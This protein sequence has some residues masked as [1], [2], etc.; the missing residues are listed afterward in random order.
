MNAMGL[1]WLIA[2]NP[3]IGTTCL[4]TA[5]ILFLIKSKEL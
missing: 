4:C 2:G 1:A 3:E 5:L